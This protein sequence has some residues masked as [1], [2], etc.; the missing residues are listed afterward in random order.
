MKTGNAWP[1]THQ[2]L[3]FLSESVDDAGQTVDESLHGFLCLSE[4]FRKDRGLVDL[5]EEVLDAELCVFAVGFLTWTF[6][7]SAHDRVRVA[8][9]LVADHRCL[10]GGGRTYEPL[11]RSIAYNLTLCE[12]ANTADNANNANTANSVLWP[13]IVEAYKAQLI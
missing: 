9:W 1:L 4:L 2:S 8:D 5:V 13:Q 12:H 11:R 10:C 7:V 3:V 6:L